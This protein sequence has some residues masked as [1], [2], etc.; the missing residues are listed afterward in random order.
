MKGKYIIAV[1]VI[2]F[3]L[4]RLHSERVYIQHFNFYKS[5]YDSLV[6]VVDSIKFENECLLYQIDSVRVDTTIK[7]DEFVLKYKLERIRYYNNIAQKVIILN[8]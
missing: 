5:G 1:I 3:V 6:E 2:G 7:S 4:L 8:I